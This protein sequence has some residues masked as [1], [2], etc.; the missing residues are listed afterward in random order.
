[1][2]LYFA[3]S[4]EQFLTPTVEP[5]A[6]SVS[7]TLAALSVDEPLPET[8]PANR[9]RLLVQSPGK[10]YL[11]WELARD[12][13]ATLRRIMSDDQAADYRLAVRLTNLFT[14]TE[15]L[16]GAN[17]E[18]RAHWFTVQAGYE[19]KAEVGLFAPNR[20]FIRLLTS[21]TVRTPRAGISH[22][23]EH[24]PEFYVSPLEFSRVLDE[25]GYASDALEVA[26]EAADEATHDQATRE[27]FGRFTGREIFATDDFALVEIRAL[28][29]ALALGV[30]L[31][32]VQSALSP[33]FAH[34]LEEL[35]E[36]QSGALDVTRLL[37]LLRTALNLKF[38]FDAFGTPLEAEMRLAARF[39]W[40]A[41]R[42]NLPRLPPHVWLPSMTQRFGRG[43]AD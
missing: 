3:G 29:A 34:W 24:T 21:N 33:A 43:Q 18:S 42:V 30:P 40:S 23:T 39:V 27:V 13:F 17:A 1:M 14:R 35:N 26:L 38:S 19:Y 37:E 22:A 5:I 6:P 16:Q 12:P 28:L 8:P 32:S 41:S 36:A 10:L 31:A 2:S 25:A 11:Y 9:I 15:T 7:E 4:S 20:A